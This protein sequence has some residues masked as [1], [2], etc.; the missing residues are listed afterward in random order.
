MKPRN[1]SGMP[2]RVRDFN[3]ERFNN[4]EFGIDDICSIIT[5]HFSIRA[6]ILSISLRFIS[7]SS[8]VSSLCSVSF[9]IKPNSSVNII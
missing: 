3:F 8:S 6:F 7:F 1:E 9:L 4:S 5:F 2:L